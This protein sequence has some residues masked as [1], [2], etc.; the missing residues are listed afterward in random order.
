M[1]NMKTREV[2]APC[3]KGIAM[4]VL[5]AVFFF[6]AQAQTLNEIAYLRSIYPFLNERGLKMSSAEIVYNTGRNY[7]EIKGEVRPVNHIEITYYTG[8][9]YPEIKGKVK[10]IGNMNIVY[11][12]GDFYPEIKGKVKTIGNIEVSYYTGDFYPEIKGKVKSIGN[13]NITY[14]T[15]DFYPEIKGKIKSINGEIPQYLI[16]LIFELGLN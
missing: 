8:D 3:L 15:G 1:K 11:Y 10:S 12:T 16:A 9:F 6:P 5:L 7:S 13:A 14:Y 4:I 2:I